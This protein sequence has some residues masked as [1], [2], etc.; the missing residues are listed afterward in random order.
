MLRLKRVVCVKVVFLHTFILLG[1]F[2][3]YGRKR[4]FAAL[5]FRKRDICDIYACKKWNICD[6]HRMAQ[7]QDINYDTGL[8]QCRSIC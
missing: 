2:N 6:I 4:R 3:V 7:S 1:V 5:I 8:L